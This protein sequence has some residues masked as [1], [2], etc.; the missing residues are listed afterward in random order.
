MRDDELR[1]TMKPLGRRLTAQLLKRLGWDAKPGESN[2][3]TLLRPTILA[4]ASVSDQ[5]EVV[6]E[7]K[8]R[9]ATKT[10]PEDADPD[11]RGV[12]YGTVAREGGPAELT[13]CSVCTMPVRIVRNELL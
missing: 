5:P 3:D 9:F 1:E 7:A 13:S 6:T 8:R 12:I 2:F 4:L 11:T 10:K